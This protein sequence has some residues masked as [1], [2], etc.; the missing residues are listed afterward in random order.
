MSSFFVN[1]PSFVRS[2]RHF[3][4]AENL[5]PG[6]E[7]LRQ[8]TV[9]SRF[10]KCVYFWQSIVKTQPNFCACS[11]F[12]FSAGAQRSKV[13]EIMARTRD[14]SF[15]RAR[16]RPTFH[17]NWNNIGK[18]LS[19]ILSQWLNVSWT[20]SVVS[21]SF[22]RSQYVESCSSRPA[23]FLQCIGSCRLQCFPFLVV[24]MSLLISI[25]TS[26]RNLCVG[27]QSV[28]NICRKNLSLSLDPAM[29]SMLS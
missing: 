7:N 12:C 19:V 24:T 3:G 6:D 9:T 27:G 21:P 26:M 8:L 22:G 10:K 23:S 13:G 16:S 17:T 15:T 25:L 4:I 20:P 2:L 5:R 29:R 14:Y 1:P 28:R 11:T 18:V